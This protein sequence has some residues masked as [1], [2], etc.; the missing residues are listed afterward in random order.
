MNKVETLFLH[1]CVYY[2][3]F[4][5]ARVMFDRK[6]RFDVRVMSSL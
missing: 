2:S 4:A 6:A 1:V 5:C 3:V